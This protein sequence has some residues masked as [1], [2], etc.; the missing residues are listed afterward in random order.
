MQ[1]TASM[2]TN[3]LG[4]A[5]ISFAPLEYINNQYKSAANRV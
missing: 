3:H 5:V 1:A 2:K 4:I